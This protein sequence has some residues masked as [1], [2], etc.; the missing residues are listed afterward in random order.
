MQRR[1]I[2]L[3]VLLLLLAVAIGEHP[4]T[5]AQVQRVPTTSTARPLLD[6]VEAAHDHYHERRYTEAIKAYEALLEK[7]IA[8]DDGSHTPLRQTQKDSI[9][10]MLGQSYAKTG[11]DA[12]AQRIFR[13]I[14]DENPSGS[15][16][17]RAVHQL[18]SLHWERYQ[19]RE[20]ILQ[21]KQILKQ[22]PNTPAASTAAY[23]VG[24]YQQ[25][26]GRSEE[27]MKSYKHF[28]DNFPTSPYRTTAVNRLI[29]LYI[30]NRRYAEAE[31]LIQERMQQYPDDITLL[32]Q[33]AELYQQQND[34]PKALE[35]YREAIKRNPD[36]TSLRK[37]LG[38]L[39]A[40]TGKTSQAVAEW[41]KLV[42]G[43]A[44]RPDRHQQLG[45]IYLSHKMYPEAIAAY[46]EAVRLNPQ[47][48]YLYTQLAAAYK[49]QGKI[50]EAA[51]VYI[52]AL[53][54]IGLGANQRETI[55]SAML[56]IYEGP[57]HKPLQD[58]LIAQ[59]QKQR[60]QS[61]YDPNIVITLGELFFYAGKAKQAL[62]TFTQLHR[63]YP[64]HTDTMLERYAR[65][66]ERNE[67]LQASADFYNALIAGS[68]DGKRIRDARF[69]LA[70]LYQKME[71]WDE[72]VVLLKDQIRNGEA[73]VKDKLLLGQL[74]LRGLRAPKDAER[75]FQP[76]LT[77]R[78]LASQLMEAQLGLG[79]CH[80]LL[81]RYTLAREVL[82]PIANR[83]SRL[84]A[85]A[86]KLVGDSYFFASDFEQAVKEYNLVIQ[87][88][89]SDRL[90]NDALERIVLIQNHPDYFKIPLTDYATAVQLYLSGNT[91]DALQQ[92]QRTFEIYPQATIVDTV[93][94]L[95]GNIYREETKD[96]EAINAYQQIVGEESPLA[97]KALV[98]I[99]EIY[100]RKSDLAN[101]AATYTTLITDYPENVIVVHA[102]QQLDE[103]AKL[104]RKR[105]VLNDNQ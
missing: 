52:D 35:L 60:P 89:K 39:Y 67:N 68:A 22:H 70:E 20:A 84:N 72:A 40:E 29:Q 87:T 90:T 79:E 32:E 27:A 57:Q 1:A 14:V 56:E 73:S 92:C 102:R 53:Q 17:T 77:Q 2:F 61:R 74:Q 48:S 100:R 45:T 12:A 51:A 37:K 69:K 82:E 63:Y 64:T 105:D 81:K 58:K 36:N 28:L 43:G 19:F 66:L 13:E 5:F 97:A 42:A 24:Q 50:Q 9:R 85:T 33:L 71:Q 95:I 103:I 94:L 55:W 18:A 99:A 15:D 41:K 49:I 86:R 3:L 23:L 21:C 88:S 11:E 8:N 96:A 83:A 34:Y 98:N 10:L 62:D 54:N 59:L 38:A 46:R 80:I 16:A 76:L 65:V 6:P 30:T 25:A 47:D 78:L 104:Q 91:E 93:W 75:T 7:G 31:K 44:N 26:E 101:A 4:Y